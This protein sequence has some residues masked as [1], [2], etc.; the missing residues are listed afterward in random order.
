M[1]RENI[2]NYYTSNIVNFSDYYPF[3]MLQ[4]NRHGGEYR[5]GFN[6]MEKDDEVKGNGNHLDFGARCYDSRLGRWL[7]LDAYAIEYPSLS[8][9]VFVANSPIIFIDPDGN[10][11]KYANNAAR[12]AIK[13]MLK[14]MK[15]NSSAVLVAYKI[16]KKCKKIVTFEL[17]KENKTGATAQN[18]DDNAVLPEDAYNGEG[19][20]VTIT[21]NPDKEFGGIDVNGSQNRSPDV[22]L[23]QEVA[24]SLAYIYGVVNENV[25]K[26]NGIDF[27]GNQTTVSDFPV[28][29]L[30]GGIFENI[31]RGQ[32][33]KPLV[34]YYPLKS[35]KAAEVL[36]DGMEGKYKGKENLKKKESSYFGYLKSTKVKRK[37]DYEKNSKDSG[38]S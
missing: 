26:V 28:E 20:D 35:G 27:E 38:S 12:K 31:Y 30:F 13:P 29:E 32:T 2:G 17:G 9:Y 21:F 3:G 14:K 5:Y 37:K 7:S 33:G 16:M 11:I 25:A 24:H 6:G 34:K 18:G 8:D 22:G 19:T 23:A 1:Q 10:K 4:P 15:K 36:R